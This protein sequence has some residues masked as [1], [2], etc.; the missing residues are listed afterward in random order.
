[1][2]DDGRC[3]YIRSDTLRSETRGPVARDDG[4]E[5]K[6]IISSALQLPIRPLLKWS[7]TN[8]P[9]IEDAVE[10]SVEKKVVEEV[11]EEEVVVEKDVVEPVGKS[12]SCLLCLYHHYHHQLL[13]MP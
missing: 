13:I 2:V 12:C 8:T 9:S 4:V 3:T 1:V 7:I 10:Q 6:F 11:V 5:G